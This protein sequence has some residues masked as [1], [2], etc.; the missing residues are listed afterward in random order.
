GNPPATTDTASRNGNGST[1]FIAAANS[2]TAPTRKA[3]PLPLPDADV[4]DSQAVLKASVDKRRDIEALR[5]IVQHEVD[6]LPPPGRPAP[7]GVAGPTQ[8][9]NH[10]N[11]A[12][13]APDRRQADNRRRS[14]PGRAARTP[15]V[16][17][18]RRDVAVP[19]PGIGQ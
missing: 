17:P 11:P 5:K 12:S 14:L 6:D 18:S 1:S 15:E 19:E 9:Q 13:V 10:R 4:R 3:H 16:C 2:S 8:A 7:A